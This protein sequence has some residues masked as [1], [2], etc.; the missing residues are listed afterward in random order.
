MKQPRMMSDGELEI[1]PRWFT[2]QQW[3]N[4]T[5]ELESVREYRQKRAEKAASEAAPSDSREE[6]DWGGQCEACGQSPIVPSS[7]MCGPCTFGD[8]STIGGN[9]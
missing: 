8:A 5:A 2:G 7:G 3:A 4:G 6:P 1:Q 9:W